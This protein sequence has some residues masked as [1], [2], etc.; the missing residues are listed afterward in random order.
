MRFLWA[1]SF[2]DAAIGFNVKQELTE[3]N[4]WNLFV[5]FCFNL[6]DV[7]SQFYNNC[8]SLNSFT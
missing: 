2:F 4:I 6:G 7:T 8:K 5:R 3:C 1:F